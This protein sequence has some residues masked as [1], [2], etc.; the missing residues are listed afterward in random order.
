MSLADFCY[1]TPEEWDAVHSAYIERETERMKGEWERMR[2]HAAIV[3]QPHAR[4][5][6]RPKEL[7]QFPWDND[8]RKESKNL[9]SR[10]EGRERFEK[11]LK[12]L[13]D[14]NNRHTQGGTESDSLVNVHNHGQE[15]GEEIHNSADLRS[16]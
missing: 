15:G 1:L 13:E 10:E 16:P 5:K 3:I 9:V 2:T 8:H 11:L 4:K 7:L 12:R 6:I 14:D